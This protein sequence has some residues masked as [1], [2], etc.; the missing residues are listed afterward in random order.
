MSTPKD[1]LQQARVAAGYKSPSDAAARINAINKNTIISNENGHRPISKK[2]ALIYSAAF[3]VPAGWLLYGHE[4]PSEPLS[5]PLISWV[6]AGAISDTAKVDGVFDS[7]PYVQA[8]GLDPNGDWIALR[9]DGRSM[10]KIS[11][12]D[13]VIFVN[14][15]ER[16]LVPNACYVIGDGNGN[17]SYK[18]YRPPNIFEPVST[19]PEDYEVITFS[20]DN[21]PD[22][23]GRVRRTILNM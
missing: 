23:I 17:A 12:H 14:R 6:S 4:S 8:E 9:V 5:V 21:T 19:K 13:S 3:G 11:P 22:I 16:N 15:K 20:D 1:R 10:D 7:V 2:M 18:R